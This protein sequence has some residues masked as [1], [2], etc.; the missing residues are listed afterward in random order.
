MEV[1]YLLEQ[2]GPGDYPTV[3]A[4]Q[5][6][7]QSELARQEVDDDAGP[8][9]SVTNEIKLEIEDLQFRP[10]GLRRWPSGQGIDPRQQFRKG[11]R[12]DQIVVSPRLK[13][14]DTVIEAIDGGQEQDRRG[15]P[16]GAEA[17]H[18]GQPVK[19]R[20]HPIKDDD[21][22]NAAAAMRKGVAPILDDIH[23][24]PRLSEPLPNVVGG[25]LVVFHHHYPHLV[26]ITFRPR[27]RNGGWAHRPG[28]ERPS[29]GADEFLALVP[30]AH[31]DDDPRDNDQEHCACR[32]RPEADPAILDRLR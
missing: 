6:L 21:I 23:D 7:Q 16:R 25:S 11:E 18:D 20:E 28:A 3:I 15:R 12:L 19:S 9:T 4:H 29:R 24:V 30:H 17:F 10:L 32:Y 26:T 27:V 8:S 13:A 22:E 2:H 1:P 5:I 31:E 14:F